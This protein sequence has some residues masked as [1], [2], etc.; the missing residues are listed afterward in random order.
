MYRHTTPST[1]VHTRDLIPSLSIFTTASPPCPYAPPLPPPPLPSMKNHEHGPC[2][3][4]SR[5][6]ILDQ[7]RDQS[8]NYA[9][10]IQACR[11]NRQS[12]R[13]RCAIAFLFDSPLRYKQKATIINHD[14]MTRNKTEKPFNLRSPS[15]PRKQQLL[16]KKKK[17]SEKGP[18][19]VLLLSWQLKGDTIIVCPPNQGRFPKSERSNSRRTPT[20]TSCFW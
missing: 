3:H 10:Q 16:P 19:S 18:A 15:R 13:R 6:V 17:D 7:P 2:I 9:A 5:Q 8:V 20:S 1:K 4:Q 14:V 12:S 11:P